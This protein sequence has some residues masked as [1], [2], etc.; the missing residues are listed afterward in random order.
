MGISLINLWHFGH[1]FGTRNVRKSIKPS[2]DSCY[3]LAFNKNLSQNMALSVDVQG[4]MT[5]SE[6]KQNMHK[7]TPII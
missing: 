6:C 1:N 4:P 2:K 5:S 3:S 7:H